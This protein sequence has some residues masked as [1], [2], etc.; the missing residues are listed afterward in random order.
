MARIV[1]FGELMLRLTPPDKETF[2][3]SPLFRAT[4][5]G[6]EANVAVSLANFG[7]NVAFVSIG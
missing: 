3:Q 5:G 4:F 7:E 2:L 6:A 1:T